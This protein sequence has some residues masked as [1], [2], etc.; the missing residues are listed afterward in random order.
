M[1]DVTLLLHMIT[2][3]GA[4][5]E[6][7]HEIFPEG[8]EVAPTLAD[9]E[10]GLADQTLDAQSLHGVDDAAGAH[11][12]HGAFSTR[13]EGTQHGIMAGDR[14]LD[15]GGI[16]DVTLAGD[17]PVVADREF[18]RVSCEGGD[19]VALFQRLAHELAADTSCRSEDD[20]FHRALLV[21]NMLT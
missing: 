12:A 9:A 8:V 19:R 21:V 15:G 16:Q 10:G 4:E 1:P 18:C 7:K 3:G 14:G 13:A 5:Q 2:I 11:R 17:K 20:Q 6:A